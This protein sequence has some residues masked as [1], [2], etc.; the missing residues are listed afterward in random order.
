MKVAK[1]EKG[2]R[3]GWDASFDGAR[4]RAHFLCFPFLFN[5]RCN[6]HIIFIPDETFKLTTPTVI[7]LRIVRSVPQPSNV[8][9]SSF[10]G[11]ESSSKT[12]FLDTAFIEVVDLR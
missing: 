4:A 10:I 3:K 6:N 12:G 7:L 1:G 11:D 2:G 8:D 5:Y 9:S